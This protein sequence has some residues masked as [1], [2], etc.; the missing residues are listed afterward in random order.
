M[1]SRRVCSHA[2]Q[3]TSSSSAGQVIAD[4]VDEQLASDLG[5][6][7][8]DA[9]LRQAG[10]SQQAVAAVA[11]VADAHLGDPVDARQ[12]RRPGGD[13]PVLEGDPGGDGEDPPSELGAEHDRGVDRDVA[14]VAG[15]LGQR[16]RRRR[17]RK[18][19]P[20]PVGL[21]DD[22]A[23]RR[24]SPPCRSRRARAMGSPSIRCDLEARLLR[25]PHV[26]GVEHRQQL[27]AG[28][29]HR[30][31]GRRL[32]TGVGL[33][34]DGDPLGV[35]GPV[36]LEDLRRG[37]R[38]A[39]VDDDDVQQ[40][41]ADSPAPGRCRVRRRRSRRSCRRPRGRSPVE[42]RAGSTS[43]HRGDARSGDRPSRSRT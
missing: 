26:V 2:C 35:G 8:A 38:R 6:A 7:A 18:P 41:R 37:V 42:A 24:R 13:P 1:A 10:R 27:A 15:D 22:F 31:V 20:L 33:V 5:G 36:A 39:V 19:H 28:R 4:A 11:A 21:L 30:G 3:A 17:G 40:V 25:R 9:H 12:R 14:P 34:D 43:W 29:L 16:A 23:R 32:V